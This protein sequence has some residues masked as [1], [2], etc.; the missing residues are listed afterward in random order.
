M[1]SCPTSSSLGHEERLWLWQKK[2]CELVGMF[3][4]VEVKISIFKVGTDN[5]KLSSCHYR[6]TQRQPDRFLF[7]SELRRPTTREKNVGLLTR[8]VSNG[9]ILPSFSISC[10]VA[11]QNDTLSVKFM[12]QSQSRWC[13]YSIAFSGFFTVLLIIILPSSWLALQ[14]LLQQVVFFN[15]SNDL[16]TR[17]TL[18][19]F[20]V[21]GNNHQSG[22]EW[23]CWHER[24]SVMTV[25]CFGLS[26]L[27][28]ISHTEGC[29]SQVQP[30]G[31]DPKISQHEIMF[32]KE[33]K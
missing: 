5:L 21:P 9:A 8:L 4:T 19:V 32:C 16:L 18:T 25:I 1:S 28:S 27:G 22:R 23:E 11:E 2:K 6:S 14:L 13:L 12:N 33:T 10:L 31:A 15:P 20:Y 26:L 17:W 30:C 3:D 29:R 24:M 7:A